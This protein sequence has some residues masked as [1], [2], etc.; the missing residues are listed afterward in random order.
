RGLKERRRHG[1]PASCDPRSVASERKRMRRVLS[2]Y[3]KEDQFNVDETSFFPSAPPDR[4]LCSEKLS[5][6]KMKKFRIMATFCANATGTEKLPIFFI[7]RY[8]KPRCFNKRDPAR[9]RPSLYY[10]ANQKAWM[11]SVLFEDLFD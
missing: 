8:K 9:M 6:K 3:A 4:T 2:R 10:R 11:T 7:G 5:G 1:E